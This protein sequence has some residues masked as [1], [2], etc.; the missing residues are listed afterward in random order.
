M[1]FPSQ[2]PPSGPGAGFP[3]MPCSKVCTKKKSRTNPVARSTETG[4]MRSILRSTSQPPN[5]ISATGRIYMLQPKKKDNMLRAE[6]VSSL[7]FADTRVKIVIT[8]PNARAT[9]S[10]SSL[11]SSDRLKSGGS[12]AG[13]AARRE[14]DEVGFA[15]AVREAWA[16]FGFFE[17]V[18]PDDLK[19]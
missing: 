9:P 19:G 4:G 11:R 8:P 13:T 3:A 7:R 17:A 6:P 5:R 16:V 2:P 18:C 15:L 12:G 14:R 10:T 1:R